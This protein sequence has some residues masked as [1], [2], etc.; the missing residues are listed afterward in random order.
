MNA[1]WIIPHW[2][3]PSRVRAIVTTRAGGHSTGPWSSLNLGLNCGDDGAIVLK[4]RAVL[5]AC[6]PAEPQWLRQAHGMAVYSRSEETDKPAL[7]GEPIADAQVAGQ[8]GQICAVLTADC[9]PVLFCNRAGSKV[10]AAHAGWRGLAA[11]VLENTLQALAEPPDQ[12]MAWLGPA[13]GPRAYEVGEDVRSAF[14]GRDNAAAACFERKG[15]KW[16]FDL[17]AMARHRLL[18]SGVIDVSGGTQCTYSEPERFFSH[19]RDGRTGRMAS[20]VWLQA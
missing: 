16:L 18:Q 14:T 20:L 1:D 3:A 6:L 12:L 13:I 7:S 2:P 19:R 8:P 17:Y 15:S 5:R 11:G 4:N 10:A 9:L